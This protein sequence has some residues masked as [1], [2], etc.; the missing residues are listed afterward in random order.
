MLAYFTK[1]GRLDRMNNDTCK[2]KLDFSW[3]MQ[4]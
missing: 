2:G 4:S 1:N 3:W